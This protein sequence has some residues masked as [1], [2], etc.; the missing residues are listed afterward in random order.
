[1]YIRHLQKLSLQSE[2]LTTV[3]ESEE[4]NEIE[5]NR[6]HNQPA[7][8]H[9]VRSLVVSHGTRYLLR[10]PRGRLN[11]G[12]KKQQPRDF[13]KVKK[14]IVKNNKIR[15]NRNV[16]LRKVVKRNSLVDSSSITYSRESWAKRMPRKRFSYF[17]KSTLLCDQSKEGKRST[18]S[19]KSSNPSINNNSG[20]LHGPAAMDYS[21]INGSSQFNQSAPMDCS[22]EVSSSEL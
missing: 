2:D 17:K 6:S 20:K 9:L 4:T 15:H 13:S 18:A 12:A 21:S 22:S 19:K 1:M 8:S 14:K 5:I 16:R 3:D 10:I 11:Y 7:E